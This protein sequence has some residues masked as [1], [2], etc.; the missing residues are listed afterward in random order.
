MGKELEG[1][2]WCCVLEGWWCVLQGV[3]SECWRV[4]GLPWLMSIQLPLSSHWAGSR[5]C[6]C[7]RS[8]HAIQLSMWFQAT[9]VDILHN[10]CWPLSVHSDRT[11]QP[12]TSPRQAPPGAQNL[13]CPL[14]LFLKGTRSHCTRK[15]FALQK[16]LSRASSDAKCFGKLCR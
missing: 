9:A 8:P 10:A 1:W 12:V 3:A 7:G 13:T 5:R 15:P 16:S 4:A 11:S 2:W 14:Q 6:G